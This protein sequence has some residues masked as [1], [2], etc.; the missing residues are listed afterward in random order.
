[1]ILPRKMTPR[2]C[3]GIWSVWLLLLCVGFVAPV[4]AKPSTKT[5]TDTP[6]WS[7]HSEQ[8]NVT[9][10][11][12]VGQIQL[13]KNPPKVQQTPFIYIPNSSSNTVTQLD[14]KTG[15][16][17]WTF[18]LN[19]VRTKS[20][21]SRTTVDANGHVWV[22]LRGG[23]EVVWISMQ[24]TLKKVVKIGAVPRAITVDLDGNV[25][26]GAWKANTITK[27][28]G[29]TGN[30]I[31]K[32]SNVP[33][34]YGAVADIKNNIW[35][36]NNCKWDNSN[37]LTKI[38]PTGQILGRYPAPGAYGIAT[39]A[40]GQ[41]WSANW[42]GSCLLRFANDGSSL[43]CIPLGSRPRGVA[44]DA[45]QNVWIPCSHVGSKETKM[46]VKLSSTGQTLGKFSAVGRHSIG[47]AIDADN[48]VWVISYAEN[49]AY[50]LDTKTGNVVGKYPTG[51]S[52]PY[53]YSDMTGF[54]FQ[55]LSKSAQGY[56]RATH[57]TKCVSKWQ[58]ISWKG[59]EPP[60]TST[61]VRARSAP[62]QNG[63]K[64]A[65]WGVPATNGG[66]PNVPDYP[67]IEVE[68]TFRTFD[69]QV[70]P[71]VTELSLTS[72]PA[73][74]EVCNGIDDDCDGF[75]D[76]IPGT[77]KPITKPCETKCGKG[78][79]PCVAGDWSRCSAPYP[80]P[81]VC[82]GADDDCD[83]QIDN[84][85]T[86]LGSS[87]CISGGCTKTCTSECPGGQICK[88]VDGRKLCV[89]R[90]TCQDMGDTCTN[91]GKIC[92]NGICL[93]PCTGIKCPDNYTCQGGKCIETDC[94][95]DSSKCP[96]GEVCR[97]GK[98]V[99]QP[100]A[101]VTCPD[102]EFCKNG[103]C[104]KTCAGVDCPQGEYCRGGLCVANPCAG[105]GCQ[106]GE[107]CENGQCKKD[108]CSTAKCRT[109][110]VCRDGK[111]ED[112]PCSVTRC[113]VGQVC[114]LP[115]GDC[116][117]TSQDPNNGGG[118]VGEFATPEIPSVPGL[119]SDAGVVNPPQPGPDKS[120]GQPQADV[121]NTRRPGGKGACLCDANGV[122]S[123]MS[124]LFWGIVLLMLAGFRK[125]HRLS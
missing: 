14:T 79:S 4:E 77:N 15:K 20:N 85:A 87:V 52:G 42:P 60:G 114:R 65:K 125:K 30:V 31:L 32:V 22:G 66:S 83:G 88:Q 120:I 82:N 19:Q 115:S 11:D 76:N 69:A 101:K 116:Y 16:L 5:W 54:A 80:T 55:S 99:P 81:E 48:F 108:N 90:Q 26:A 68:V 123:P 44:V 102:G 109:G 72:E 96:G 97:A 50:K 17:N 49:T 64:T 110:L 71:F 53:T 89:G 105:I 23:D 106:P 62:T 103:M 104:E 124:F 21:P 84:A 122:L 8:Q 46:V 34:P 10:Q 43:G 61:T 58:T 107:V 37:T 41:V 40:N 13:I 70:T 24:G 3:W 118:D 112:D 63:L 9:W 39:D 27:I 7:S 57:G 38:S 12:V 78:E 35:V 91:Q 95:N 94:Y 6:D 51:G 73:G 33:C 47:A 113:P 1:M 86:C 119:G 100:C 93:D 29:K 45:D 67:W 36:V 111:C 117:G 121:E 18:S 59:G 25:W 92:R 75:V 28:D 2:T 74:T 56:W 98:C